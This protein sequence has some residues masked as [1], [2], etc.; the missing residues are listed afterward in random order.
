MTDRRSADA[1]RGIPELKMGSLLPEVSTNLMAG[2][3]ETLAAEPYNG[4]AGLPTVAE[5]RCWKW[6]TC[7][8]SRRCSSIWALPNSRAPTS[9]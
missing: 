9:P 2:L 1:S 5:R 8:R 7:S 6:T 4:H 3:I